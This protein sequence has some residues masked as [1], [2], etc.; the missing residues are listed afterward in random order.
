[1][2]EGIRI[3]DDIRLMLSILAKELLDSGVTGE[4][5][6]SMSDDLA[7]Y[8][9]ACDRVM[10]STNERFVERI[11]SWLILFGERL[12]RGKGSRL[13]KAI[14]SRSQIESERARARFE[15]GIKKI[16]QGQ[17]LNHQS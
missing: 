14:I 17:S 13:E 16:K 10:K 6:D 2:D 11:G 12:F 4:T 3:G 9:R 5:M 1:M 7:R 15:K 8:C